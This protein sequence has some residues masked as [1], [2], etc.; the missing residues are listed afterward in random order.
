MRQIENIFIQNGLFE[1]NNDLMRTLVLFLY[2]P[3]HIKQYFQM[4]PNSRFK[5]LAS[6]IFNHFKMINYINITHSIPHNGDLYINF[7]RRK[8]LLLKIAQFHYI[9]ELYYKQQN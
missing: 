4:Y 3:F 2:F 5:Y 6:D 9:F 1:V 7:F 8:S